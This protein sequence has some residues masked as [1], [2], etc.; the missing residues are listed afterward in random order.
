ML[1]GFLGPNVIGLANNEPRINEVYVPASADAVLRGRPG[2][3]DPG[4][5]T[6]PPQFRVPMFCRVP[7]ADPALIVVDETLKDTQRAV[8]HLRRRR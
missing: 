4:Y 5:P 3:A 6:I 7:P 2:M 1:T 8:G